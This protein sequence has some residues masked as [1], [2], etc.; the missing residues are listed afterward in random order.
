MTCTCFSK[1]YFLFVTFCIFPLQ[2]PVPRSVYADIN[3]LLFIH[4]VV[5]CIY[6]QATHKSH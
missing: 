6:L 5:F 1:N 4:S 3:S 2:V